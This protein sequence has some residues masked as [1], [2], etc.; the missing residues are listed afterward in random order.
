MLTQ[1]RNLL[2]PHQL[3]L[4]EKILLSVQTPRGSPPSFTEETNRRGRDCAYSE[5]R[6]TPAAPALLIKEDSL[7]GCAICKTMTHQ[8]CLTGKI[9]LSV[10]TPGGSPPSFTEETNRRGRD[11]NPR[12]P[13]LMA[14]ADFES[15]AFVHSAT[16]PVRTGFW[17]SGTKNSC[18]YSYKI[19]SFFNCYFPG[20]CHSH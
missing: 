2:L 18:A 14:E 19:C 11:S 1:R 5:K 4:T 3:C 8:L 10:Q 13:C 6:F 15:A 20:I 17:I 7:V 16:S 9:L 12:P